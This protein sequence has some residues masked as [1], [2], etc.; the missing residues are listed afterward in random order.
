MGPLQNGIVLPN[1]GFK[2][3]KIL[4]KKPQIS[5]N[6]SVSGRL[7]LGTTTL[8]IH[9]DLGTTKGEDFDQCEA[10]RMLTLDTLGFSESVLGRMCN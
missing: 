10:A 7:S 6:L 4:P 9:G 8:A 3:F 5:R 2:S 1:S